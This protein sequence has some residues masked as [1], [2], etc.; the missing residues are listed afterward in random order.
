MKDIKFKISHAITFDNMNISHED[1]MRFAYIHMFENKVDVSF[2]CDGV[3]VCLYYN[4][5]IFKNDID[6]EF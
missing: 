4:Q 1:S 6:T 3:T 2:M 5:Y